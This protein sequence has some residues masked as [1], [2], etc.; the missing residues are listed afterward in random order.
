MIVRWN[1]Q[2]ANQ[3]E[4]MSARSTRTQ[5]HRS[6]GRGSRK[7][8]KFFFSGPATKR[9]ERRER[10]WQLGEKRFF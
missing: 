5:S 9:E 10:A 8:I 6:M 4:E 3:L 1:G 7:K 2:T